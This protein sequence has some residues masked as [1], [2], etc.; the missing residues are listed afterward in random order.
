M[1]FCDCS[2]L[3]LQYTESICWTSYHVWLAIHWLGNLRFS[4]FNLR[5][6]LRFC[7]ALQW[8][9]WSCFDILLSFVILVFCLST[10]WVLSVRVSTCI[11]SFPLSKPILLF[12]HWLVFTLSFQWCKNEKQYQQQIRLFRSRQSKWDRQY[13][14]MKLVYKTN[15]AFQFIELWSTP[16]SV[17][18]ELCILKRAI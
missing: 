13:N 16:N 3:A 5:Y 6:V 1:Y 4:E 8:A 10:C 2:T 15:Y 18:S 14:T 12:A 11:G 17:N 9:W 7:R